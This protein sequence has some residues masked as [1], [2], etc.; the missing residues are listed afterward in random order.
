MDVLIV[1]NWLIQ[2]QRLPN[3]KH[4]VGAGNG[5]FRGELMMQFKSEGGQAEGRPL[6]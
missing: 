1:R 3:Q 4:A 5:R 2:L 6:T